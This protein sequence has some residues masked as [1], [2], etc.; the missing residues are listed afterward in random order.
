MHNRPTSPWILAAA[1]AAVAT[2]A[3]A[4]RS[5]VQQLQRLQ[6]R[7]SNSE[8]L[9]PM[10]RLIA[11]FLAACGAHS[12]P[13]LLQVIETSPFRASRVLV[14]R[15]D[16]G[17]VWVDSYEASTSPGHQPT[18]PTDCQAQVYRTMADAGAHTAADGRGVLVEHFGRC[19][20]RE[21]M[22][23]L[24]SVGVVAGELL[25]VIQVCGCTL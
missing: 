7:H 21:V 16:D 25:V 11:R 1:V 12:R 5:Y 4:V 23:T 3:V 2:S 8:H 13:A 10:C 6:T 9:L 15:K 20:A 22:E 17:D 19:Y 14:F 24:V 18:P